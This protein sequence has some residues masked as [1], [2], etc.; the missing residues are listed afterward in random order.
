MVSLALV[1]CMV[2]LVS[3]ECLNDAVL[4]PNEWLLPGRLSNSET[5]KNLKGLFGHLPEWRNLRS[6]S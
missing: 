4:K 6:L 2:G 5:L 1:T 3:G